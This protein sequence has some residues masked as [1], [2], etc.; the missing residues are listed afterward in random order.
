M[1][2]YLVRHGESIGNV[3]RTHQGENVPLSE[4]GKKQAYQLS[5]RLKSKN[6]DVIYASPHLR[7]RQTAE[8]ISSNL[9]L[10]IEYWDQLKERRR[11]SEIEGL[12][13]DDPKAQKINEITK[14]NQIIA[15]WKYSDD[16][17]YG[18]LLKRAK[19]IEEHLINHHAGQNVVC[20]S[21]I[22]IMMLIA[23]HNILHE[24]LSPEIF[25][26]FYHHSRHANTGIT[27]LE[28][29]EKNG[30]YLATWNDTSHL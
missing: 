10:P 9:S 16:E 28:Y 1:N 12:S 30:W 23:L 8:I 5:E 18:D 17:S 13:Y 21:H 14:T 4:G 24:Q 25:S 15:E 29:S 26:Q 11:P 3:N 2:L 20:V 19:A 22:A 27:H 7:T 6:I